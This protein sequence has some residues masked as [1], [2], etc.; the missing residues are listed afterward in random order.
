MKFKLERLTEIYKKLE[1]DFG[2]TLLYAPKFD[3][4]TAALWLSTA[5]T[6]ASSD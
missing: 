1:E 3:M 2:E 4:Q 5:L 6:L